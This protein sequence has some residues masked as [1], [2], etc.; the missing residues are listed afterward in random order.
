MISIRAIVFRVE[1]RRE[2]RE[3]TVREDGADGVLL[4][5][6]LRRGMHG[7]SVG[8]FAISAV[9]GYVLFGCTVVQLC[10]WSLVLR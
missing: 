9:L 4:S 10:W 8:P 5:E 1:T 2:Y 6:C 3:G 7:G